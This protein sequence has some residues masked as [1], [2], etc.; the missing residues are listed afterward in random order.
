ME[1]IALWFARDNDGNLFVYPEKP[2]RGKVGWS[3]SNYM[4]LNNAFLSRLKPGDEP[5]KA[6]IKL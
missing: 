6:T 4:L 1:E 2:R 3:A 5:I